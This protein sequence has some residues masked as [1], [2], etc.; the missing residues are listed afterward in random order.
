MLLARGILGVVVLGV[1]R[2]FWEVW[3]PRH[4]KLFAL[5][6]YHSPKHQKGRASRLPPVPCL[7]GAEWGEE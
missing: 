6:E 1:L 3:S 4:T 5:K 2:A 7:D